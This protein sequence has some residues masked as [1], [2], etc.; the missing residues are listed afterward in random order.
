MRVLT[1]SRFK[2]GLDCPNKLFY[3]S[4][5]EYENLKVDDPFMD[6]LAS[7]GFQVEEYARMHYPGGILIE[8]SRTDYEFLAN[9]TRELLEQENVII[10]EA[11]FLIDNLFIRTDILVKQGKKIKLIEVKAKGCSGNSI[12]QFMGKKG[13]LASSWK[14]YLFDLAFQKYVVGA[15]LSD[16]QISAHLL[17]ADKK[18]AASVDGMN[19]FFRIRKSTE[20]RTGIEKRVDTLAACGDSVLTEIAM[21]EI[22]HGIIHG[23]YLYRE[24]YS[25][26]TALNR[27]RDL[28]IKDEFAAE[29]VSFSKC[30]KCE[31][32][33][34]GNYPEKLSGLQHCFR[35]CSSFGE[36]DRSIPNIFDVWNFRKG[37]ELFKDGKF[38]MTD[39]VEGDVLAA[40]VAGKLAPSE[41][42]WLQIEKTRSGDLSIHVDDFNLKNEM[43]KWIFPLHFIDFETSAVALPF[44]AGRTPYEQVAFQFSHHQM[45]ADGSVKHKG[46]FIMDAPGVF[47]NFE[48]VRQL[49]AQLSND[50]GT[51]FRY[52]H[53][54]NTI[55][56]KINHQLQA[57]NETD[58]EELCAFIQ[59]ITHSKKKDSAVTWE[60]ARNMIDLCQVVKDFYYNP[61]MKGS[62]SIKAVLPAILGTSAYLQN[63]YSNT[64]SEIGLTSLNFPSAHVWLSIQNGEVESPYDRLPKLFENWDA[65]EQEELIS[66]MA[67]VSNG[68]AAMMAYAKLQYEDMTAQE[69]EELVKGLLKY[70]EL[71]TLA[72]VMLY[73]ELREVLLLR[74]E[75]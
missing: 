66:E 34:S 1:K 54:E 18:K 19:Q 3:T 51:I 35:R 65:F 53:H 74:N 41:R 60:G 38:Y 44:T 42:Q 28:Y 2:L 67:D 59:T 57:S 31:F 40:P 68:G 4:K 69:R 71:D 48:F 47:P 73:E 10:Y 15:C 14:P 21:N 52:S 55:L 39:L 49:K 5:A 50:E 12:D 23:E 45:E 24:E 33:T 13:G 70:C 64:I 7:G 58:R 61:L 46:E 16:H 75:I 37:K 8:E 56:V 36:I 26:M 25:F 62:N 22:V 6:A 63:K 32:Q 72:M 29:E 30:K 17:L 20:N 27:L 9:K 11:A 43:A